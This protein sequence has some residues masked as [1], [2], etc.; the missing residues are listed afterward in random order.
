MK[1]HSLAHERATDRPTDLTQHSL[2]ARAL[3]RVGGFYNKE[4]QHLRA[5]KCL[6]ESVIEQGLD[7]RLLKGIACLGLSCTY[8]QCTWKEV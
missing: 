3:L 2:W 5:A 8:Q 1:P 4:S 6:F 7:T